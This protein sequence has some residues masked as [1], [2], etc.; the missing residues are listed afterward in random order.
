MARAAGVK[1]RVHFLDGPPLMPLVQRAAGVITVN[2]TAAMPALEVGRPV[3]AL[4]EAVYRVPGI[5]H[6]SGLDRFWTA[7]EP[8][9]PALLQAFLRAIGHHVHVVGGYYDA[10]A[11]RHAIQGAADRL[12]AGE[13]RHQWRPVQKMHPPLHPRGAG[14]ARHAPGPPPPPRRCDGTC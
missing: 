4:G 13:E 5:T 12:E 3:L 6:E 8:P 10:E 7:P 2:S 1:G 9:D 11:M 14:H